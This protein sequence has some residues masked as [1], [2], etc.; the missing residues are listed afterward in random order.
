MCWHLRS[1]LTYPQQL[2]RSYTQDPLTAEHVRIVRDVVRYKIVGPIAKD[3]V[4][5]GRQYV[6]FCFRCR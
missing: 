5:W 6:T 4:M 2:T 3:I 1:R